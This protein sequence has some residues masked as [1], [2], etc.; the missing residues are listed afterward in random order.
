MTEKDVFDKALK[1]DIPIDAEE[2]KIFGA[3]KAVV[4]AFYQG[5]IDSY[6]ESTSW[7]AEM[8]HDHLDKVK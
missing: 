7:V 6:E 2:L 4:V 3:L 1:K 8:L 5:E